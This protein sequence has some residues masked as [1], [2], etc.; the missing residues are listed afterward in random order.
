MLY[1]LSQKSSYF[2]LAYNQETLST[3][4]SLD[5]FLPH[6]QYTEINDYNFSADRAVIQG[7]SVHY[8]HGNQVT[9]SEIED[10]NN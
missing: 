3:K 5:F 6:Y 4:P 2:S 9:S 1:I 7:Q 8:I 10:L